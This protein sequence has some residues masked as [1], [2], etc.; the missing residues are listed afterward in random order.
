[1]LSPK[2][3]DNASEDSDL[4]TRETRR[5]NARWYISIRPDTSHDVNT[6]AA[7]RRRYSDNADNNLR[8]QEMGGTLI[9][10]RPAY[11]MSALF[12]CHGERRGAIEESFSHT[13]SPRK[14]YLYRRI[15]PR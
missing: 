14:I 10:T 8:R 12:Y 15:S 7:F 9:T 6:F 13:L 3:A 2:V 5:N 1:M 4:F 11:S